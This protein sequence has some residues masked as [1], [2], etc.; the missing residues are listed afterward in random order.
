MLLDVKTVAEML[1]CKPSHVY[2]LVKRGVLPSVKLGRLVR[3]PK[4][5]LEEYVKSA[6]KKIKLKRSVKYYGE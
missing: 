1:A 5:E 6:I 4:E 2:S 3:V